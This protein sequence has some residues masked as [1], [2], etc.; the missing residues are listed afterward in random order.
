MT[1]YPVL[2]VNS[3][4]VEYLIRLQFLKNK[5]ITDTLTFQVS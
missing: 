5:M 3:E 4:N 2:D 1:S